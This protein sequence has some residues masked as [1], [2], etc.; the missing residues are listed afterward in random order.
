MSA[1]VCPWWGGYFI[2]NF[3][4]RL[5]HNPKRLL[6]PYVRP[7]MTVVDITDQVRQQAGIQS[8]VQGVAV[9]DLTDQNAPA[10]AAGLQPGDVISGINGTQVRNVL[11][12][13]KALNSVK[14][15]VSLNV[16]RG[17]TQDTVTLGR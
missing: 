8:G 17:G 16:N 6:G 15:T 3:L 5:I 13:Y 10:A 4:R 2:D 9:A 12:F 14:G 1:H 7:G 11:D